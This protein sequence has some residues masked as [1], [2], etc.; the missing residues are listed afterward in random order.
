LQVQGG[1]VT[2]VGIKTGA[3]T[4]EEGRE[5]SR[6]DAARQVAH[7]ILSNVA[8]QFT[9]KISAV[10]RER[11]Y[12]EETLVTSSVDNAARGYVVGM[13]ELDSHVER[14]EQDG[15]T[16]YDIH[17]KWA[18][19][20]SFYDEAVRNAQLQVCRE[21]YNDP[22]RALETARYYLRAGMHDDL[23]AELEPLMAQ[24]PAEA[25]LLLG[26]AYEKKGD[27]PRARTYYEGLVG[28]FP[29]SRDADVAAAR[30]AA[31]TGGE[32]RARLVDIQARVREGKLAEALDDLPQ[33]LQG[34]ADPAERDR[35][36][37]LYYETASRLAIG[38]LAP[39]AAKLVQKRLAMLTTATPE[40]RVTA[41]AELLRRCLVAEFAS[42]EGVRVFA[43]EITETAV[44]AIFRRDRDTLG[45]LAR[46]LDCDGF[47]YAVLGQMTTVYLI[48]GAGAVLGAVNVPGLLPDALPGA[49]PAP[50]SADLVLETAFL[51]KGAAGWRKISEG[52]VLCSGD[53]FRIVLRASRD[54]YAYVLVTQ[55]QGSVTQLLPHE[56]VVTPNRLRGGELCTVPEPGKVFCLD[57]HPGV[58]EFLLIASAGD[59]PDVRAALDAIR[60]ELEAGRRAE[61]ARNLAG[62]VR[63]Q[64]RTR[65]VGVR[66]QDGITQV[67]F[68][69]GERVPVRLDR[70]AGRGRAIRTVSFVHR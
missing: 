48:D 17:T 13:R 42:V 55:S 9:E 62:E 7:T 22:V 24:Q 15:R 8:S 25:W 44:A 16:V 49:S 50:P 37:R 19:P 66:E 10:V 59:L 12:R 64:I 39:A 40:G 20:R 14:R 43:P 67:D 28:R 18:V 6:N 31:M 65:G 11:D 47:V 26:Q 5:A 1:V 69:N 60:G 53:E 63:A 46:E 36:V 23:I 52:D 3:A 2:A 45:R 21:W 57:N 29:G 41:E 38:R 54:A 58:E 70:V 4:I 30:L 32:A 27:A 34:L 61:L 68:A 35:A 51:V 56:A 33:A